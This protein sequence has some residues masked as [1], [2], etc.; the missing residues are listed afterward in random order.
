M[1]VNE[2]IYCLCESVLLFL[3]NKIIFIRV[4][5]GWKKLLILWVFDCVVLVS[6]LNIVIMVV[7]DVI[8]FFCLFFIVVLV[9]VI[10]VFMM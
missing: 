2:W 3:L 9:C 8:M 5:W 1:M 4:K 7:V 6:V 10:R